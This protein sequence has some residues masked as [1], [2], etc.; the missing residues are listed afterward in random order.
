MPSKTW[1]TLKITPN[2]ELSTD[3]HKAVERDFAVADGKM[4]VRLL[5]IR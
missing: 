1:A 5:E 4:S 3:Q 2:P